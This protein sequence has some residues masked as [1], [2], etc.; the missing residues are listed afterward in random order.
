MRLFTKYL[1]QLLAAKVHVIKQCSIITQNVTQMSNIIT[2][3]VW[4][5]AQQCYNVTQ[6]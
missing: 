1:T 2:Q 6:Q 5:F 4:Q 3:K